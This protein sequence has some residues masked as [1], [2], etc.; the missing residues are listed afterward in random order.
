M[1]G[2]LFYIH[3][4]LASDDDASCIAKIMKRVEH[5]QVMIFFSWN[6][7]SDPG[8]QL[9]CSRYSLFAPLA[10]LKKDQDQ[11]ENGKWKLQIR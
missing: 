9:V 4:A 8:F 1:R 11:M 10:A 3:N 6:T 7:K 5:C 2:L